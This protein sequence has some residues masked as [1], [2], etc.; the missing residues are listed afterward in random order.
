MNGFVVLGEIFSVACWYH[1]VLAFEHV[2]GVHYSSS[3]PLH[4]MQLRFICRVIPALIAF[5]QVFC[6]REVSVSVAVTSTF[7]CH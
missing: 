3:I 2:K 7:Q 4:M 5:W 6:Y 1:I